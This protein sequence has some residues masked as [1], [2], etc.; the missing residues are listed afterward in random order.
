MSTA[1]FQSDSTAPETPNPYAHLNPV[2]IYLAMSLPL[3]VVTLLFWA[4]FHFW[5][6]RLERQ[7]GKQLKDSGYQV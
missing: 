7:K 3:T 2:Q 5:E 6:V 4:G 1:I